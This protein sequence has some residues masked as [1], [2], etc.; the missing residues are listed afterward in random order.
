LI[1]SCLEVDHYGGSSIES[2]D[3][4][5]LIDSIDSIDSSVQRRFRSDPIRSDPY[6]GWGDFCSSDS[7]F[8][9]LQET[10]AHPNLASASAAPAAAGWLLLLLCFLYR[11]KTWKKKKK[12]VV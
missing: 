11:K 5:D 10:I 6:C 7:S 2:I 8:F 4:I 12:K 9:S 1:P 3:S